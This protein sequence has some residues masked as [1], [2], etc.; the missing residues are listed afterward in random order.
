MKKDSLIVYSG[1]MDSTVLLYKHKD[2]IALAVSFDYGSKHNAI[3]LHYA[4]YHCKKLGIE[5]VEIPLRFINEYFKSNLLQSGDVIPDGHY[6]DEI[7]K[8][9]VVPFRNG[10][11]MS[12]AA[13][14]A[15]SNGLKNILIAAHSGD[16]AIYPDCREIFMHYMNGA[17]NNGTYNE[18]NVQAPFVGITKRQI[19][20][21][22]KLLKID[23]NKTW[24]C[25]KGRKLFTFF[26][27]PVGA[28]HCG[29]CGT[30]VER[31]EALD[32]FDPT[33]YTSDYEE[34]F[35]NAYSKYDRR[36]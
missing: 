12:I 15:E 35:N 21:L 10:I 5:H 4:R 29:T 28:E 33:F 19:A 31:K 27:I 26:G 1:G 11:M 18:V 9:T 32:G 34:Y 36:I 13:G 24:S 7:M 22:G 2:Q 25:Y 3:E 14:L 16:H 23:F 8:K 30:C 17:I 6:E 20:E